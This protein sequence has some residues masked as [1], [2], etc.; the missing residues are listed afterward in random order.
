M[1]GMAASTIRKN[2]AIGV[3]S[4]AVVVLAASLVRVENERYALFVGMCRDS[5]GGLDHK[6][7]VTV[8]TR[9]A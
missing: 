3:L 4:A 9:T 5:L 2:L 6:C 1:I 7:L 8:E